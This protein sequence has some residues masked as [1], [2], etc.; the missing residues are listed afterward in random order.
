MIALLYAPLVDGRYSDFFAIIISRKKK[1]TTTPILTRIE[2]EIFRFLLLLFYSF[3]LRVRLHIS[4]SF[5]W[6]QEFFLRSN[7]NYLFSGLFYFSFFVLHS[8]SWQQRNVDVGHIMAIIMCGIG[9]YTYR[10]RDRCKVS[11]M[12]RCESAL[13]CADDDYKW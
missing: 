9:K 13:F 2:L 6:N 3:H 8:R 12:M 11:R 10:V 1:G 5:Y 4:F 7:G